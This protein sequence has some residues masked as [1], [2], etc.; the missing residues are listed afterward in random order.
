MI[1]R[2]DTKAQ[3]LKRHKR[4]RSKVSGTPE[5]PRL[6]VF[7][8][9]NNIYAQIIDDVAGN[10]LVAAS[11]LDKEITGNGGNKAAARAVGK[12]IAERAKAKG[13]NAVVFDRGGYLYHGRVAELAEGAREGGLEF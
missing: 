6:N 4:V 8:S 12:L 1:K 7:R 10:T 11:S 3:R 5:R 2:P 13:I 9:E